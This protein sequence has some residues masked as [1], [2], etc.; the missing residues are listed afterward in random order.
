M[1]NSSKSSNSQKYLDLGVWVLETRFEPLKRLK[2][3]KPEARTVAP[4]FPNKGSFYP[5]S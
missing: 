4:V 1:L 5:E 3:I 2:F